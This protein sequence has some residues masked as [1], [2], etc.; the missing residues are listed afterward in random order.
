VCEAGKCVV[1]TAGAGGARWYLGCGDP[2][3]S[4]HRPRVDVPRCTAAQQAGTTCTEPQKPCDPGD[5]CNRLLVCATSDPT[6]APGGCP[7]SRRD[8]KRDVHYLAPDELRRYH[9]ELLEMKLATWRYKHDPGRERLGFIIDDLEGKTSRTV[10]V[11]QAGNM[12]DLYGYTSLAVAT[13]QEQARE[14]RALRAELA[15][16]RRQMKQLQRTPGR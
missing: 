9:D 10:A 6:M 4:G 1:A 12:V 15:A 13:L 14:L 16:L 3:C 11:E 2:V 5:S 7:R 8:T